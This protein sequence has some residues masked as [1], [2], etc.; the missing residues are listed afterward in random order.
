MASSLFPG[1]GSQNAIYRQPN[2]GIKLQNLM[3]WSKPNIN[4]NRES[5]FETVVEKTS[6]L[7]LNKNNFLLFCLQKWKCLCQ[8]SAQ[9]VK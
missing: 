3:L 6:P 1:H 7:S 8:G 2:Y 5:P 9:F 4:H